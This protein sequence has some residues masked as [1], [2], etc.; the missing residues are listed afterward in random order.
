MVSE[1]D[2]RRMR[3]LSED[4]ASVENDESI[5][6]RSYRMIREWLN[7]RRAERGL[8][9]LETD[10]EDDAPEEGILER[11]KALGMVRPRRRDS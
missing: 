10:D 2:R 8:P 11:A 5:D 1:E 3:R 9:L 4:L 6:L 7:E